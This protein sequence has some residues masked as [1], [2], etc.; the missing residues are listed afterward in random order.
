VG[1]VR[2]RRKRGPAFVVPGWPWVPLVFLFFVLGA[3]TFTVAE[4]P[5]E[6]LVGLLTL[7]LPLML[8]KL[9]NRRRR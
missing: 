8:Y 7:A 3:T 2:Q 9:R 6:S 4:R 5:R 1:L